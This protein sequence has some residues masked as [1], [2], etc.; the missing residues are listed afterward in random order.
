METV[1]F[2]ADLRNYIFDHLINFQLNYCYNFW[3]HIF[4]NHKL[5]R[6]HVDLMGGT[7]GFFS[8]ASPL[9]LY[10]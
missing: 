1:R 4:M 3:Q 2:Y 9:G 6:S 7:T 10:L 5:R 8:Y